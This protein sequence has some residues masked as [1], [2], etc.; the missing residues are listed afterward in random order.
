[1]QKKNKIITIYCAQQQ[2]RFQEIFYTEMTKDNQTINVQIVSPFGTN[3]YKMLV[4]GP[5]SELK[6]IIHSEYSIDL[7]AE[8]VKYIQRGITA[9]AFCE[10][11]L[12]QEEAE[13]LEKLY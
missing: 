11:N 6:R 2:L 5:L 3:Q 13:M 10:K 1:M 4:K 9:I 12:E 8:Q 7:D